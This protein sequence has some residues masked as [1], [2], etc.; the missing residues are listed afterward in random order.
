MNSLVRNTTKNTFAFLMIGMMG[1]LIANKGLYIHTH[2]LEIGT[3]ITHSH[4]YDKNQDSQ[5]FK[6]HHH[7]KAELMFFE[8]LN[9]LFLSVF[10]IISF[11]SLVRKK[12]VFIDIEK[13]YFTQL[14]FSYQGRAPPVS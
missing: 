8:N 4:P 5:P 9:V 3:T 13:I 11:I 1:L 2:K 6:K 7:T 14:S 12:I 10:L